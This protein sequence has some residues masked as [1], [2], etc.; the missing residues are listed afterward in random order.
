[1]AR[2]AALFSVFDAASVSSTATVRAC[3]FSKAVGRTVAAR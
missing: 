3:H 1:M 2:M